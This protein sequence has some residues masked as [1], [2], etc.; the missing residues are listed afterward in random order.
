VQDG[1]VRVAP[2]VPAELG[3]LWLRGVP[4]GDGRV[5]VV[6]RGTEAQVSGVPDGARLQ[7]G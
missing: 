6:A 1:V 4:L 5:T 7:R 3:E 2:S